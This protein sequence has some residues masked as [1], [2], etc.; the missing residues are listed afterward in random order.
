M[1]KKRIVVICPGRGTYT[2][3]TSGYLAEFGASAKSQIA[4]MD[5]KRK[6]VGNTT[7]TDLDSMPFR[8]KIHMSGEHASPLIYACSLAD[9]LSIDQEKY[10]IAAITGNSMGWYIALSLSGALSH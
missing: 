6:L 8:A 3:D 5:E 9:F 4:Y 7:L 1:V 2:R 10:E